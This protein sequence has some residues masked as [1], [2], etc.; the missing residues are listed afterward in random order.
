MS[1]PTRNRNLAQK[2][3][4]RRKKSQSPDHRNDTAS[5]RFTSAKNT[6]NAR[7]MQGRRQKNR[8]S[9]AQNWLWGHHAVKAA[10]QNPR[11]THHKLLLTPK[12]RDRLGV[13]VLAVPGC[14]I[15]EVHPGEIDSVLP[16]GAVHQGVALNTAP[17]PGFALDEVARPAK[18]LLVVLDQI[19]DPHNVGAMF[20]LAAAFG[21]KGVIMQSRHAPPMSGAVAKVAVGMI[22]TVPHVLVTNIG[23]ALLELQKRGWRVT[24]LAG[25]TD[26]ELEAALMQAQAEVLVLGAEGPGLRKRVRDCCDQLAKIPMPGSGTY[27]AESLNVATAAGIALYEAARQL[28][29]QA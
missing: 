15:I 2:A 4:K 13:D 23:N 18:G 9:G 19:T 21:A 1:K 22:E 3:G 17:L 6:Q 7:F 14:E 24:G 26:L 20:R 16:E 5:K 29:K 28:Q 25:E 12:M 8:D 11:R 10:L 27:G